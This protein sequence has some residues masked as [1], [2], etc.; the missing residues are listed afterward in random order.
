MH[1]SYPL[2]FIIA[3][4][5]EIGE[6][7]RKALIVDLAEK[8]HKGR[9]IGLYYLI[10]ETIMIPASLLGG[11]LWDISPQTMFL[12]AFVVGTL[13]VVIFAKSNVGESAT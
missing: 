2:A 3:G 5:R 6:P 8:S 10:R 1:L 4:L 13:G 11:L 9:S 7:A 12:A